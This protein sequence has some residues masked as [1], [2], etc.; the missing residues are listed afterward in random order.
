MKTHFILQYWTF[1]RQYKTRASLDDWTAKKT[2]S[3]KKWYDLK[4]IQIGPIVIDT[5]H[6]YN[7]KSELNWC[8][9]EWIK[10][11]LQIIISVDMQK[12]DF[13][14]KW[15]PQKTRCRDDFFYKWSFVLHHRSWLLNLFQLLETPQTSE[16][17]KSVRIVSQKNQ[18]KIH[19]QSDFHSQVWKSHVATSA[20]MF[21]L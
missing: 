5:T 3:A 7:S 11:N 13:F 12:P 15:A 16:F 21:F 18:K 14:D 17:T 1:F 8:K 20:S 19:I 10:W 4:S 2:L 9:C 6:I